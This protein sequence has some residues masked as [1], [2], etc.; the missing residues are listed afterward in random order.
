[1]VESTGFENRH[2]GNRI[3]GS[4]PSLSVKILGIAFGSNA[5]RLSPWRLSSHPQALDNWPGSIVQHFEVWNFVS[6]SKSFWRREFS[7]LRWGLGFGEG[8][9]KKVI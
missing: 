7:V 3:E 1:M 6:W 9:W 2:P 5:P 8:S 4:N